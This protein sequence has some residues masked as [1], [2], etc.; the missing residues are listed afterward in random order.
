MQ[1][2][3]VLARNRPP[4][5]PGALSQ[6][7]TSRRAGTERATTA[8]ALAAARTSLCLCHD[9]DRALAGDHVATRRAKRSQTD[10]IRI[11][12]KR[13][14]AR[15]NTSSLRCPGAP[16]SR[17]TRLPMQNASL[18]PATRALVS[19]ICASVCRPARRS[20][21]SAHR[22]PSGRALGHDCHRRLRGRRPC[23]GKRSVSGAR[24]NTAVHATPFEGEDA[25]C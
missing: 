10:V 17:T 13:Q 8:S 2:V 16:R 9:C 6:S 23:V 24:L 25:C 20:H 21:S 19:A 18:H 11:A 7:P 22:H 4:S 5:K 14:R 12:V 15:R 1:Y 3:I